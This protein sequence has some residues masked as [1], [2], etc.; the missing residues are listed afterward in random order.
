MNKK[1]LIGIITV[2]AVLG[3]G[4]YWYIQDQSGGYTGPVEPISIGAT[5]QE[6]STLIWIAEEKGYFEENGLDATV[7]AYDTGIETKNALL[8]GEVDVADTVDF[9]IAGLGLEGIDF[10]VLASIDTAIIDYIIAR[11]DKGIL[12]LSDLRDKKIGIKPGSSAEYYL[13]RTLIFNNLSL[14]DV[15]LIAVHPPDMPEAISQGK[16]DATITWHPHNYHI[17]NILGDNA[18]VWSAQNEQDVY[19]V[20]FSKNEFVQKYPEKIKR[21]LRALIQAEDFVK[22]NNLEAKEIIARRVS[23]DLAYIE[24]V[25]SDFHFVVDL[26][27][28]ILI[29][30]EDQARWKIENSLTDATK[31]PNYLDY[32][33]LDA[34]EEV[35]PEA[36]GIIH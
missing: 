31:V 19:W 4:L 29:V 5:T 20:I 17:K 25:W 3:I 35:K 22:D 1:I 7:K 23:L 13:G 33:Y 16:V 24:S 30:M 34:L 32:I 14:Q 27:Q 21:L 8:A 2:V 18:I 15:E 6:L 10:K 36:V 11:K 26:P 28:S 9:V 12:D